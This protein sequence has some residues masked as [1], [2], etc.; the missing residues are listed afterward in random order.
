VLT[1]SRNRI[2][3]SERIGAIFGGRLV[4]VYLYFVLVVY[5]IVL[6]TLGEMAHPTRTSMPG[7]TTIDYHGY[8]SNAKEFEKH[9]EK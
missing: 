7:K 5:I 6:V 1:H 9:L 4:L 2:K 3:K 8:H